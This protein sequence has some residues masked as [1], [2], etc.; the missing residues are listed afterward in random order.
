[1]GYNVE[2][3]KSAVRHAISIV[4]N[5][6]NKNNDHEDIR[7]LVRKEEGKIMKEAISFLESSYD[8]R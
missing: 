3:V 2:E 6:E 1:M 4:C 5:S 7:F 8:V